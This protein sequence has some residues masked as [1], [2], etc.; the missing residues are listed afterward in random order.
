[1]SIVKTEQVVESWSMQIR[2]AN[3]KAEEIYANTEKALAESNVPNIKK[4]KR[5]ISPGLL[6]G[7]MGGKRDFLVIEETKNSNLGPYQMFIS[8][9][10]YGNNLDVNWY[11]TFRMGLKQKIKYLL[12]LVPVVNLLVIPLVV[13]QAL[14]NARREGLALDLFDEQDL[15]AYVTNAHHCLLESVSNVM[16]ELKQDPSKIDRKSKG[17][18]GIS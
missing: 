11:L 9:R 5:K 3:G 2:N 7:L 17:F 10:D 14:G 12:C 16:T 8:A 15:R 18:L 13:L 4:E 6:R 1:M